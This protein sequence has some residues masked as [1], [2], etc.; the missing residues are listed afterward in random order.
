MPAHVAC[1]REAEFDRI[2]TFDP[3]H[4]Q[5]CRIRIANSAKLQSVLDG[6]L[7][8]WALSLSRRRKS[9]NGEGSRIASRFQAWVHPAACSS[10]GLSSTLSMEAEHVTELYRVCTTL[11]VAWRGWGCWGCWEDKR[12]IYSPVLPCNSLGQGVAVLRAC[13]V[14]RSL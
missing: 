5:N 14:R 7:Q 13:S 8:T 12:G 1:S 3:P 2:R 6:G 9:N 4:R 11:K 10:G